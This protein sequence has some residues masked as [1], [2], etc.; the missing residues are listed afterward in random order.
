M[1][2]GPLHDRGPDGR[3]IECC[4]PFPCPTGLAIFEAVKRELLSQQPC[5]RNGE[6]SA[7]LA[8]SLTRAMK[9]F[10]RLRFLLR[11]GIGLIFYTS[12]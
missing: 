5:G 2:R 12:R 11:A 6:G 10:D 9:V 8:Y 7:T 3:C 1:L 4:E